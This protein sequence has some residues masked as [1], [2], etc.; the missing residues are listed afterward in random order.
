MLTVGLRGCYVHLVGDRE[1]D[2][3]NAGRSETTLERYDRNWDDIMQEMR[4]IQTGT[5]IMAGFLLTLAFQDRFED[6]D[7]FQVTVYVVLVLLAAI[8]TGL[9]ISAV[10][11]HRA[12]WGRRRKPLVVRVGNRILKALL[13]VVALLMSGVVMFI[14]DIVVGRTAG[15]VAGGSVLAMMAL[16]LFL[17]P[18]QVE[19]RSLDA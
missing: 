14:L 9:G 3:S 18:Q 1:P 11:L 2:D 17:L 7:Q 5:Q 19:H 16:L 15:F 4:V 6:L 10:G 12:L 13:V 8:S